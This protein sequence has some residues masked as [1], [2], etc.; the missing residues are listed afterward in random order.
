MEEIKRLATFPTNPLGCQDLSAKVATLAG[1]LSARIMIEPIVFVGH[2]FD[3]GDKKIAEKFM[4]L[5][6]LEGLN[7]LLGTS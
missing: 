1:F 4:K 7:V 2:G 5:F 6:E 3:P